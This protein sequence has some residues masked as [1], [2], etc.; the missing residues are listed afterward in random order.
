VLPWFEPGR[1]NEKDLSLQVTTFPSGAR[2]FLLARPAGDG[3][4][5]ATHPLELLALDRVAQLID[6]VGRKQPALALVMALCRLLVPCLRYRG[7]GRHLV[8]EPWSVADLRGES[9]PA[10]VRTTFAQ[11]LSAEQADAY[12]A[13]TT[14]EAPPEGSLPELFWA[15][16]TAL[17][18]L[19]TTFEG[20][21]LGRLAKALYLH[22]VPPGE[23]MTEV[24]SAAL[25]TKVEACRKAGFAPLQLRISARKLQPLFR[26]LLA[27]TVRY[28]SQLTGA[29]AE[30]LIARRLRQA[31][32]PAPAGAE[33]EMLAL[34]FGAS[35][36]LNDINVGFL[37]GCGPLLA[38]LVND[39]Y[40]T[41]AGARPGADR[42]RA[43]ELLRTFVYLLGVLQRRR[44][45]ARAQERREDRQRHAD[46]MPHGP[47]HQAELQTDTGVA[48]PGKD[49]AAREELGLLQGLLPLMKGRDA[50]RL[51]AF[52]DCGGD[53]NA[54]AER[55]GVEPRAYSR[56]LRQTVFPAV[57]ALARKEGLDLFE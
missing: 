33:Q 6:R 38:D 15:A 56:Q 36:A 28:A 30:E 34:R 1:R 40:L 46:H 24:D 45:Q 20:P 51:Q 9:L 23:G 37:F 52:I 57:R 32:R 55:L 12:R 4:F 17:P 16:H 53:R 54:A 21:D 10:D 11:E 35:R 7:S 43:E 48:D 31:G 25:T 14:G 2:D 50:A 22:L 42:A 49:A 27:V 3:T 47:R 39:Y 8:V 44:K 26:K 18:A 5:E 19:P 29:A 13:L 41:L